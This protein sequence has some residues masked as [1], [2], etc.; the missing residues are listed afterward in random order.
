[1]VTSNRRDKEKRIRRD[2]IIDAAEKVFFFKGYDEAT[3]DDVAK[4][5]EFS[6][7]T[8]Y[9]YF[10]SKEHLRFEIMIRGYKILIERI[11]MAFSTTSESNSLDLIRQ[12]GKVL[13]KFNEDF[14][15]HFKAIMTYENGERDFMIGITDEAKEECYALGEQVFGHLSEIL[16]KG[17]NEGSIRPELDVVDTTIIVWA[18]TVGLFN[19]LSMK[20]NYIENYHQRS[21][22]DLL[23]KGLDMLIVLIER[24]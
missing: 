24:K 12:F 11:E 1:M 20:K 14:P 21:T 7:R 15:N 23:Q 6:K 18:F 8:L 19:T 4:E 9:V 17:I 13:Y 2:D 3:M 10:N 22:E 5:A 16:K